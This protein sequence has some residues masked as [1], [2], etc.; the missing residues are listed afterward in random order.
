MIGQVLS[1]VIS[2]LNDYLLVRSQVEERAVACSLFDLD[3]NVN[4]KAR[5]KVVVSLVNVTEDRTYRSVETLEKR[6]DGTAEQVKPPVK[7]NLYLLLIANMNDYQEALKALD[8]V[9]SFFQHRPSFAYASMPGLDEPDG[10][11]VFELSSMSMEQVNHLWGALGGKYMP[12]VVYKAGIVNLRDRQPEAEIP[13][14][15]EIATAGEGR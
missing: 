14:V 5:D 9:M 4:Q 3:G 11:L 8:Q 1:H 7:V 13:P 12:S 2:E 10:R 6:S 15:E